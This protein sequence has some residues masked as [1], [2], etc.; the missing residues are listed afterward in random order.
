MQSYW[1]CREHDKSELPTMNEG[2]NQGCQKRAH[3]EDE[4]ANLL[5]N[6]LL[7]LVQVPV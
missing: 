7:D 1:H 3:E 4:H 5:S 2:I 6:A